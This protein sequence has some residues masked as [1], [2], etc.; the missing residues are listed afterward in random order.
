MSLTVGTG[1]GHP[2]DSTLWEIDD[3]HPGAPPFEPSDYPGWASHESCEDWIEK[4]LMCFEGWKAFQSLTS[5]PTTPA[6]DI[7]QLPQND[8]A[9]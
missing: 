9:T 3:E 4:A 5:G 7:S 8:P 6:T 2:L 1:H